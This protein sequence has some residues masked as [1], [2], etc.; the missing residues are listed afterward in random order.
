LILPI[1]LNSQVESNFQVLLCL[2]KEQALAYLS[3]VNARS[4]T[5][6]HIME[7]AD[8][9]VVAAI[10]SRI[11]PGGWH[12]TASCACSMLLHTTPDDAGQ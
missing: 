12:G 9:E 10:R 6:Q 8:E 4:T 2:Q 1:G 5:R 11:K 3:L 7:G